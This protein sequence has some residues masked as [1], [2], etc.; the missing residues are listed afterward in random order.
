ME[1]SQV[2]QDG[3]GMR[4]WHTENGTIASRLPTVPADARLLLGWASDLRVMY[5]QQH[6]MAGATKHSGV[7]GLGLPGK[8]KG[9]SIAFMVPGTVK[10]TG[11]AADLILTSL[12]TL[13]R[14]YRLLCILVTGAYIKSGVGGLYGDGVQVWLYLHFALFSDFDSVVLVW[15]G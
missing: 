1:R 10:V 11:V 5:Y 9:Q 14:V 15:G 6:V 13:G 4:I 8:Q 12:Q 7:G 2:V 3:M